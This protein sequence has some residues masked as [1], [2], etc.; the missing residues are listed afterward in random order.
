MADIVGFVRRHLG[1]CLTGVTAEQ[2]LTWLYGTGANGKSTLAEVL[3]DLWAGYGRKAPQDLLL[4][5][6]N[7]AHSTERADPRGKRLVVCT[8]IDEGRQLAESLVKEL[9]GGDTIAARRMR[10]NFFRFKPTHELAVCCNHLLRVRGRDHG[11]W[12]RQRIVPFAVT[13]RRADDGVP[14]APATDAAAEGPG[15]R[16][17]TPG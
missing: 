3:L 7:E 1:Y 17:R 12:R 6:K 8:E 14:A 15:C 10:E 2:F 13:F 11:V 9:T 5:R 4:A 16:R